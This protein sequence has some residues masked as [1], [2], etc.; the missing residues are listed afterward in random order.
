MKSNLDIMFYSAGVVMYFLWAG[1]IFGTIIKSH[2]PH[3]VLEELV[4]GT[5]CLM[6]WLLIRKGDKLRNEALKYKAKYREL[7]SIISTINEVADIDSKF[8][9]PSENTKEEVPDNK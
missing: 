1:M 9:Q 8:K 2:N 5:L 6:I 4:A 3:E 7:Q